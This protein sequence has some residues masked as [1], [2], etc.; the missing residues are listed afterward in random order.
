[1]DPCE[2]MC[3]MANASLLVAALDARRVRSAA[4]KFVSPI[5]RAPACAYAG[6]DSHQWPCELL[7]SIY[8]P[9]PLRL[10]LHVMR[11]TPRRRDVAVAAVPRV[12]RL[13]VR[14]VTML[15]AACCVAACAA[16]PI[17]PANTA[18]PASLQAPSNE[19]LQN[20]LTAVGDMTYSCRREDG[21]LSWVQTGPEATL[22]DT[23]R[24]T[25]GTV[26]PGGYFTANDGSYFVG[27]V[28]NEEI[29]AASAVSWERS[30][31]RRHV[32]GENGD[33]LFAATTSV[34]R[35]Q[36]TGGVPPEPACSQLGQSLF[37]PY[38]ATYMFYRS[39]QPAA[40]E[41][42]TTSTTTAVTEPAVMTTGTEP[43]DTAAV[44]LPVPLP[45]R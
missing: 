12:E 1:M 21:Q 26:M 22:V 34:Q 11:I 3:G 27:R 39:A 36:T 16:A 38:T 42:T 4:R 41:S 33:G 5:L 45:I 24:K 10:A 13:R 29:V 35:V 8:R 28:T 40:G 15:P 6:A 18:L 2:V 31:A 17:P 20:V 7:V 25:V 43:S 44:P 9:K 30:V 37:V 23:L 14:V 19:V 32:K